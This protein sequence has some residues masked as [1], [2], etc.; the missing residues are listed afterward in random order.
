MN[1]LLSRTGNLSSFIRIIHLKYMLM[2][3]DIINSLQT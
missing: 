1:R 2:G 3:K